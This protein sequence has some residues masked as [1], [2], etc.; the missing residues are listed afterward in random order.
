M[1][2]EPVLLAV[3]PV[4]MTTMGQCSAY[5]HN[6]LNRLFFLSPR[7]R[8]GSRDAAPR[9][10]PL[11]V[12]PR[13]PRA[14]RSDTPTEQR[15]SGW[16]YSSR[17]RPTQKCSLQASLRVFGAAERVLGLLVRLGG[18]R[19]TAVR[20]TL[21][22]SEIL[23]HYVAIY[24]HRHMHSTCSTCSQHPPGHHPGRKGHQH[25]ARPEGLLARS[26]PALMHACMICIES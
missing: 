25:I 22:V 14:R 4:Q 5:A 7:S 26:P 11:R 17:H 19:T 12:R 13:A 9:G 8:R 15:G 16:I 23:T 20:T 24:T 6:R 2:H 21:V 10:P 18:W 1:C 3:G